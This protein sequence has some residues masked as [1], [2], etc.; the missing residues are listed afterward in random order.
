MQSCLS[1]ECASL[2]NLIAPLPG[3]WNQIHW[4]NVLNF[5]F[6]IQSKHSSRSSQGSK[7]C[8]K[9]YRWNKSDRIWQYSVH[10]KRSIR[11]VIMKTV[12]L[13]NRWCVWMSACFRWINLVLVSMFWPVLLLIVLVICS[14]RG[15]WD[16]WMLTV[17]FVSMPAVGTPVLYHRNY[18]YAYLLHN[19]SCR[20]V[21]F[22]IY[23]SLKWCVCF[24]E[25]Q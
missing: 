18:W 7:R 8:Y 5:G 24:K 25:I 1:S 13:L 22:E 20:K 6:M 3:P 12:K 4:V 17:C 23:L 2:D 9:M 21:C 16:S 14:V 15:C 19:W 10:L 11:T